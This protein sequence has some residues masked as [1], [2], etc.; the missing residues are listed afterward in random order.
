[1]S[2]LADVKSETVAHSDFLERSLLSA[3][4]KSTGGDLPMTA[5]VEA[6]W[7]CIVR[8]DPAHSDERVSFQ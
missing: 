5:G 3:I 7:S 6:I 4:A 1:M 2:E 8:F